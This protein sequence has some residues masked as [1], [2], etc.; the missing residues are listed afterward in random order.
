MP[1]YH[2]LTSTRKP[3]N[4]PPRII[5]HP[6][7][8]TFASMI[9]LPN[10]E[11]LSSKQTAP[12]RLFSGRYS[13]DGGRPMLDFRSSKPSPKLKNCIRNPFE[14][15]VTIESP[16]LVCYGTPKESTGAL[17]SGLIHLDVRET[18]QKFENFALALNAEVF[19]HKPVTAHCK[20]C[21]TNSSELHKWNL[22]SE[23][24]VLKK[25]VHTYPFSYLLPG[26]L[27]ASNNNALSKISYNLSALAMSIKGDEVKFKHHITLRRAILPG[28]DRHSIRIFP[29]TN[30]CASVKLPPVIH[31]GGDFPLEIRLDGV[32]PKRKQNRWRLRKISWRIDESTSVVSPACK[33][34]SNK[35][36]GDGKGMLH[37]NVRTVGS[38]EI[39]SGWKSDFESPGG[40]I[41]MEF[42][43][44]IPAHAEAACDIDSP[45]GII[46]F[47]DLIVELIVAEEHVGH[48]VSN[49]LLKGSL[50][51]YAPVPDNANSSNH[52][53]RCCSSPT[54]EISSCV[55]RP[56]WSRY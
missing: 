46:V 54:Y 48:S 33:H 53:H 16:P 38:G 23:P 6:E 11:S 52:S 2:N 17:L 29:P 49:F 8:S 7:I 13:S 34:H 35:L 25:G 37:E 24:V 14:I 26:H 10:I 30:L 40:K 51:I 15:T 27:P 55:H 45:C 50:L 36:G 41:E 1:I 39:K 3:K 19:T 32:V 18:E 5:D 42:I 12:R 44:G 4:I 28:H 47:H 56:Q 22:I 9:Y 43:A 31:P 21:T 20:D